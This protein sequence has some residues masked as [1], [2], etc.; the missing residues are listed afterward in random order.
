[1]KKMRV[2]ICILLVLSIVVF[3]GCS[4][5]MIENGT[6]APETENTV[7]DEDLFSS[8]P[9]AE[10]ELKEN[11]IEVSGELN[12]YIYGDIENAG[13][14]VDIINEYYEIELKADGETNE[15]GY[16]NWSYEK[17]S[18]QDGISVSFSASMK[19]GKFLLYCKP[20]NETIITASQASEA[21]EEGLIEKAKEFADKFSNI[22]GELTFEC[23]MPA[24][25]FN[26]PILTDGAT[27]SEDFSVP[28]RKFLFYSEENSKQTV[29]ANE[30]MTCYVECN[31]GDTPLKNVQYFS[32][33]MLA[34]GTVVLAENCITKADIIENGKWMMITEKNMDTLLKLFNSS[35]KD[36][37]LI[38]S[39]IY[40]DAYNNYFGYPEINPV[41]KVEYCFA[42]SPQDVKTTEVAIDTFVEGV[43]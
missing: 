13:K 6:V 16:A 25:D 14:T 43:G 18:L 22:T 33:V 9:V 30:D 37:K 31:D 17:G 42:S 27:D 32:V 19:T 11:A 23:S 24:N 41:L 1:M 36:D 39:R 21:S 12:R 34:D 15:N 26:Y 3:S 8:Y 10:Y 38:I 28:A 2:I 35:V 20:Y 4:V 40:V 5:Q 7:E 29:K